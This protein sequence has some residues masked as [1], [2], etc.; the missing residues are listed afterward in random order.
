VFAHAADVEVR[1]RST[2][3]E[4]GMPILQNGAIRTYTGTRTQGWVHL[5]IAQ[6][7]I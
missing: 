6:V 4:G 5:D 2:Y 3:C 7:H 1:M